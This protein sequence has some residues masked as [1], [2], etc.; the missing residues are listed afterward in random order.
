MHSFKRLDEA[1]LTT[2]GASITS[3]Q[4]QDPDLVFVACGMVED[5]TGFFVTGTGRAWITGLE[6]STQDRATYLW[7][8]S[9]WP[10]AGE[11]PGD[12]APGRVTKAIWELSGTQ[13][14]LDGTGQELEDD[15][16]SAL[17]E[18]YVERIVLAIEQLRGQGAL[19]N[20]HG[21]ELWI[22]VHSADASDEELDDRT[23]ARLN[24]PD[25]A[26]LF[27]QRW[28]GGTAALLEQVLPKP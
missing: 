6:G 22:W 12:Q 9:E 21:Q 14:M 13:T 1:I 7:Y 20:S 27:S 23:F 5:L 15:Q 10:L 18:S 28:A 19:R 11:D 4:E 3:L 25:L 17:R 8:P 26:A 24:S 16:Y 2:L